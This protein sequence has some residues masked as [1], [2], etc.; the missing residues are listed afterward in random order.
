M[1]DALLTETI[2][3][4][5]AALFLGAAW[6]KL[7]DR[8]RFSA[9]LRDYRLLPER[10][11]R[12]MSALIPLFELAMGFLWIAGPWRTG[13]AIA[14][15]LLLAVYASAIAVNMVRGRTYID[16]GCT[17]GGGADRDQLLSWGLVGRNVVLICLVGITL[18]PAAQR[19]LGPG[20]YLVLATTLII[21]SVLYAGSG[22]LMRNRAAIRTWRGR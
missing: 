10:L 20:D 7:S 21:S 17:F 19:P 15:A 13:V 4:G 16:C 3:F 11:T 18:L 9:V 14:S 6:H 1:I 22:Q 2:A 5:I 8:I 12:P